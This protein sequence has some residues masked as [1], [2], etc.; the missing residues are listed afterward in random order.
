MRL[1]ANGISCKSLEIYAIIFSEQVSKDPE[2]WASACHL[3]NGF[4]KFSKQPV[5]RR[6]IYFTEDM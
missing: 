2:R 4:G 6:S 3:Q 5:P 1:F